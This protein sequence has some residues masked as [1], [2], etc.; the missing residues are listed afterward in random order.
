M[1]AD[2]LDLQPGD[3]LE[4]GAAGDTLSP[5]CKVSVPVIRANGSEQPIE[6]MAASNARC[7]IQAASSR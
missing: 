1:H 2:T 5:G 7:C 6:A 3:K 4:V